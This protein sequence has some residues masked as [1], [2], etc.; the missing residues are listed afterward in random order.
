MPARGWSA[1]A[2]DQPVDGL[3]VS[4]GAGGRECR[5]GRARWFAMN[6]ST[7]LP[8]VIFPGRDR[9]EDEPALWLAW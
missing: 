9:C 6:F 2:R 7:A 5:P 4:E 1:R 3:T 8:R